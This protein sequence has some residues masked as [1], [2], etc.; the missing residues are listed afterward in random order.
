M[1]VEELARKFHKIYQIGAKRQGGSRHADSYDELPEN[2][3]DLI[4]SLLD[5][6]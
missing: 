4:V 3:K 6:Y 5:T 2:I 1:S